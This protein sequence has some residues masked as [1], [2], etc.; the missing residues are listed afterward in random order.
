M[1]LLS[2][3]R[4]KTVSLS[5]GTTAFSDISLLVMAARWMVEGSVLIE[6]R[7]CGYK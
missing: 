4:L 6:H 1:E 2:V 5:I 7:Q 3:D